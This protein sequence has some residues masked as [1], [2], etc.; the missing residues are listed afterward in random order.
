[1]T[2]MTIVTIKGGDGEL[3]QPP[4]RRWKPALDKRAQPA[5]V[6]ASS[7]TKKKHLHCLLYSNINPN[8]SNSQ[9][10]AQEVTQKAPTNCAP[11]RNGQNVAASS[12]PAFSDDVTLAPQQL[13]L[14]MWLRRVL[15]PS[16][17]P[18]P[19]NKLS[20][21]LVPGV[22]RLQEIKTKKSLKPSWRYDQGR[23]I[24]GSRQ[25]AEGDQVEQQNIVISNFKTIIFDLIMNR[26]LC[27]RWSH[28][29][30]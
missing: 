13:F 16:P 30:D 26:T 7:H 22:A 29:R 19:A 27:K 21:G 23:G 4:R 25:E 8:Q 14:T 17:P 10:S 5:Q 20:L 3:V 28:E 24:G 9:P 6:P 1:M 2:M 11:M 12:S 18:P 15:L